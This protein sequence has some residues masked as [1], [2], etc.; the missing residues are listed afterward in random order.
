MR[1]RFAFI[2]I[3]LTWVSAAFAEEQVRPNGANY[4]LANKY[5]T[6]FLRQFTYDSAVTPN[7]IGKTDAFWYSYRT[8]Q[9]TNFW[10]VDPE[11]ARKEPLF[12]HSKVALQLSELLQKPAEAMQLPITRASISEDGGKFKFV[13][14]EWQFEYD[15]KA[16]KLAKLGKAPAGASM[17]RPPENASEEERR[18]WF[19][20]MRQ[21]FQER[22]DRRQQEQRRDDQQQQQDERRDDQQQQD[23]QQQQQTTQTQ[24]QQQQTQERGRGPRTGGFGGDFRVLTSDRKCYL[25]VQKHNLYLVEVENGKDK[26]PVQLTKDGA[27]EY[28]FAPGGGFGGGRRGGGIGENQEQRNLTSTTTTTTTTPPAPAV[29]RKTRPSAT[30]SKDDKTF[31][32]SRTDARG[33]RE[34]YLV[35]SLAEPRPALEKYG[36]PMPGEDNIRKTELYYG[37]RASTQLTRLVPKWRDESYSNIHFGKTPDELRFIRIDR[38]RR[39]MEFCTLNVKTGE[40]KCL[41]GEGFEAALLEMQPHRYLE[42]SDEMIWWSERSGWGHYYLYDRMGKLKNPITAGS[43]RASRVVDV[44]PKTRTMWFT[45]NAREP[46]ENVYY[47]HLYSIKL[48]GVGLTLLDP[49]HANHNSILS[50]TK[51]YLVD[52]ST[53]VD[54][55]PFTVLRDA[56]G[57]KVMDLEKTDLSRLQ[58]VGWKM[59]ETFIVKA[60]DGVTDLYGNMWKPFDFDAKKKYPIIAHVYPGPQQEGVTHTFSVGGNNQQMAQLGFI[61]IQ[62]GHRGGTPAR[63]KAY[64]S[65]G[66]FN[67][68]DYGLAD[69]KSAIEQLAARHAWID[70]EKVG[71]YGHSGGGFMSAAA[72][73]QKPYNDFFKAAVA[74]AGNHDNNIYNN[75]WSERYHGMKEVTVK[76]EKASTTAGGGITTTPPPKVEV[77]K[78]DK[79]AAV[80]PT[81][82]EAK[83][84]DKATPPPV[85]ADEKKDDKAAAPPPTKAEVKKDDKAAA[86]P[87]PVKA[88]EAKV[89][90]KDDKKPG[91]DAKAESTNVVEKKE[92]VKVSIPLFADLKFEIKVPTN[93][94]LAANLKGALMLVH[95]D[96][97]N[98]VHPANTMRLVDALIKANKR[99]DMLMIPGARHGFGAAQ[100]YFTQRMWDFFADHLLN[101]RT[102]N[103]DIGDKAIRK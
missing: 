38:L 57:R 54:Q 39:H 49:G 14:G 40:Q 103:A 21:Q 13:S 8:S 47:Q 83:K 30:W 93:T 84:D 98:N 75:S 3:G 4:A 67:M 71:I 24:T 69:K 80:P 53:R 89:E 43:F 85:K 73:L 82:V 96:M 16:E 58:E 102:A 50:P 19:E 33:I 32:V 79:G 41:L 65:Y 7:F 45:A 86:T 62:V 61:V 37:N 31:F 56:T 52:N 60:A 68:R 48:D 77:K 35:N 15:L 23:Q 87:P 76:V 5:S 42:E 2:A 59:P 92:E 90:K 78:D 11:A 26:E 27:E 9:G 18:R 94:E 25:Y 63:S 44:D 95:G 81:K 6:S 97:D 101:H 28:S 64:A 20:Q 51:Q 10:R 74:S 36:Y 22:G 34:L 91:P 66:Y 1:A 72:L 55:G 46:Q 29:D 17:Q 99:F 100:G 70:I 88:G 12:N